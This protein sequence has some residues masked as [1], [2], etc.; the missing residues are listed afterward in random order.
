MFSKLTL[1]SGWSHTASALGSSSALMRIDIDIASLIEQRYFVG[2]T[3]LWG[4]G[5]ELD[6]M[7]PKTLWV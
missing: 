6:A 7:D 5:H 3:W 2:G 1:A 4:F